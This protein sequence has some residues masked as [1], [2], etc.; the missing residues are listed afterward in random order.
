MPDDNE[1]LPVSQ[2]AQP[3]AELGAHVDHANCSCWRCW[4][5]SNF[6]PLA[7]LAIVI[8]SFIATVALMHEATIDDKYVTWLEGFCAGAMT[9]LAVSMKSATG[10]GKDK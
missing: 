10:S 6:T 8:V 9:S 2:P 3:P 4:F 5:Q 7:L 1:I